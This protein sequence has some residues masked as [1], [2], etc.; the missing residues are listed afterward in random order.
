MSYDML[1]YGI[2]CVVC[3]VMLCCFL[4]FIFSYLLVIF[5][6][7]LDWIISWRASCLS[8]WLFG[9]LVPGLLVCLLLGQ[10]VTRLYY[11]RRKLHFTGDCPWPASQVW[12]HYIPWSFVPWLQTRT[13]DRTSPGLESKPDTWTRC[14]AG[15]FMYIDDISFYWCIQITSTWQYLYPLY[16]LRENL[17]E[18]GSLHINHWI[19]IYNI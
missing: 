5:V 17:L 4:C 7:S 14:T 9:Y 10:L 19:Y 11:L 2:L 3:Y 15:T 8:G 6:V 18:A 12:W 1:Y 13:D 16:L